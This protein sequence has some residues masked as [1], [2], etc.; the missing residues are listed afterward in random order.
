MEREGKPSCLSRRPSGERPIESGSTDRKPG[1]AGKNKAGEDPVK[2]WILEGVGVEG[3]GRWH[4]ALGLIKL[5][6]SLQRELR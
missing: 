2:A 3:T 5:K 4:L 1:M 6:G